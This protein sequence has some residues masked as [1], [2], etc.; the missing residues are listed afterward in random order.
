MP[1]A[2]VCIR[3]YAAALLSLGM[4]ALF[5]PELAGAEPAW[6]AQLLAGALLGLAA[7]AWLVRDAPLGGIYGRPVVNGQQA[8]AV[9][10]ALVAVREVPSAPGAWRWALLA[11]LAVG[12]VLW[13]V[14]LYR[15]AWLGA[16]RAG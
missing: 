1:L 13:S 11:A 5:A 12:A 9:I 3:L 2:S 14:L 15:P 7:Q 10:G 16:P 4:S 6:M 8:F